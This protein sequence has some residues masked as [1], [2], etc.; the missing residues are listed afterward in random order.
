MLALSPDVVI[1]ATGG[2]PEVTILEEGNDLAVTAWD[3]LS[4]DVAPG[5][6]VL[7]YDDAGDAP[8]LM[9]AERVA[10][11]GGA[12]EVMTRDRSFAPEVMGMNLVPHM[13]AL[14]PAG[15]RL[16]V[17]EK[18]LGVTRDGNRLKARVGTDYSGFESERSV[19]QVVVN[20]GVLPLDE[21]YFALR[22]GSRNLGEVDY[23]ALVGEGD[24]LPERNAEGGYWLYR[25]GDAVSSRNVHAAIYD[26]MRMGVRW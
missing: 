25:I 12:V 7:I 22:E 1:V 9:A 21:L 17:G 4:G 20:Q 6:E 2:L 19:D 15:A 23:A 16:T 3:I 10:E 18:V 11:A 8:A 5:A 24:V 26:A 14:Q 13:K